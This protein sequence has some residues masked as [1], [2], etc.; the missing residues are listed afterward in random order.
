MAA[1]CKSL[2]STRARLQGKLRSKEADNNRLTIQIK[3][4]HG[5]GQSPSACHLL[6][7]DCLWNVL[8]LLGK[9]ILVLLL[10]G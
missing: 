3:V 5:S 4:C 8:Q 6:T 1:L 9:L 2:E 7:A 10:T